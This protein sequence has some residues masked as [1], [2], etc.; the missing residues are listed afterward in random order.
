[1]FN[2]CNVLIGFVPTVRCSC[3]TLVK[4][5]T[6]LEHPLALP[7][8]L[9]RERER[10]RERAG[11]FSS[12]TSPSPSLKM[13]LNQ[14]LLVFLKQ[15]SG[16]AHPA[17]PALLYLPPKKGGLGLPY[18]TSLYKKQQASKLVQRLSSKDVSV[19][20]V[21]QQACQSEVRHHR[22]KFKPAETALAV[23]EATFM[24]AAV[25]RVLAYIATEES[26]AMVRDLTNLPHKGRW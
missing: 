8:I 16:L 19:R 17:N 9:E 15:W 24:R 7:C 25:T 22:Q 14:W 3:R 12:T 26:E 21:V 20:A 5:G 2:L 11:H 6:L 13:K 1:M 4:Q 18:L 23:L 10:E